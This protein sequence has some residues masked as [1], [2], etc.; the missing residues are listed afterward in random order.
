MYYSE[1]HSNIKCL[2][3]KAIHFDQFWLHLLIIRVPVKKSK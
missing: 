3:S 1:E 2:K